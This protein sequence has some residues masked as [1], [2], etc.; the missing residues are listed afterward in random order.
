MDF[1]DLD[2]VFN[3]N[4]NDYTGYKR[5]ERLK[6]ADIGASVTTFAAEGTEK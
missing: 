5:R 4:V 6:T 2:I 3:C 1:S